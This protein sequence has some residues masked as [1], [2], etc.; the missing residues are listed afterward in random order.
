M[1]LG[2]SINIFY[3]SLDGIPLILGRYEFEEVELKNAYVT[4]VGRTYARSLWIDK[5]NKGYK[6]SCAGLFDTVI[7]PKNN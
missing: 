7:L 3:I 2:L 6:A 1:A 4:V 5:A